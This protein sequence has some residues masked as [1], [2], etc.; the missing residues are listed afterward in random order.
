MFFFCLPLL[1]S[2]DLLTS[3][4]QPPPLLAGGDSVGD[5]HLASPGPRLEAGDGG[6]GDKY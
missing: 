5:T 1:D 3:L 4:G 2:W 6:G